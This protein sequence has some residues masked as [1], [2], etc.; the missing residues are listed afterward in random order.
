VTQCVSVC[1]TNLFILTCSLDHPSTH[2]HGRAAYTRG[3]P[4][5]APCETS[6]DRFPPGLGLRWVSGWKTPSASSPRAPASPPVHAAAARTAGRTGTAMV[7]LLWTVATDVQPH[8]PAAT[9][10]R[11]HARSA[12]AGID[13]QAPGDSRTKHA[14]HTAHRPCCRSLHRD[15][16]RPSSSPTASSDNISRHRGVGAYLL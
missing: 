11:R 2:R 13:R 14:S 10:A 16:G 9:G 7:Q 5:R 1:T 3:A 12:G 4:E 15:W 8:H 6:G